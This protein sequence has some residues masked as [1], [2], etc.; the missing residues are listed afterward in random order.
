M[1]IKASLLQRRGALYF[2]SKKKTSDVI[3]TA[4]LE[5]AREDSPG[6]LNCIFPRRM[7]RRRFH[8]DFFLPSQRF[9]ARDGSATAASIRRL[10]YCKTHCRWTTPIGLFRASKGASNPPG[11]KLGCREKRFIARVG[12]DFSGTALLVPEDLPDEV[13]RSAG[14][15]REAR[16]RVP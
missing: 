15:H 5:A 6:R 11:S 10:G 2:D 14:L 12:I 8:Q 13:E 7:L 4:A 9:R 16:K 3:T 1:K